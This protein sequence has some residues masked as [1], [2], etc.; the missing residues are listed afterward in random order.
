[1]NFVVSYNTWNIPYRIR[2]VDDNRGISRPTLMMVCLEILKVSDFIKLGQSRCRLRKDLLNYEL[3]L[4]A[5]E[6]NLVWGRIT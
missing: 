5:T 3:W 2:I 1:V 6:F 4:G